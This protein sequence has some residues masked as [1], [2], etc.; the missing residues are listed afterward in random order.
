MAWRKGM[1]RESENDRGAYIPT[2]RPPQRFV[3]DGIRA[4][5]ASGLG[6]RINAPAVRR[7]NRPSRFR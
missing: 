4:H 3:G 1:F 5:S 2:P 7:T 6:C